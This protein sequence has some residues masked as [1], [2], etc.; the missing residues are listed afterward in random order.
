MFR[1][2]REAARLLGEGVDKVYVVLGELEIFMA[3]AKELIAELK[4]LREELKDAK[5]DAA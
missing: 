5:N 2:L 3:E 4:A 1:K